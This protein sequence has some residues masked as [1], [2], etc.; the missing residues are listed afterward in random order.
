MVGYT[1]E[2]LNEMKLYIE[3]LSE[4][5]R[6]RGR[7]PAAERDYL[8]EAWSEFLPINLRDQYSLGLF[9]F[10]VVAVWNR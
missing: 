3:Y 2:K 4:F 7:R 9:V 8:P 10:Y 5:T 6:R 1:D